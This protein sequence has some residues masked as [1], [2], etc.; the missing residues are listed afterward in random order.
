MSEAKK[1]GKRN[2]FFNINIASV[3]IQDRKSEYVDRTGISTTAGSVPISQQDSVELTSVIRFALL[4]NY[5]ATHTLRRTMCVIVYTQ[6]HPRGGGQLSAATWSG[7]R[8][9]PLQ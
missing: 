9:A 2:A 7:G 3:I 1:S 8:R 5:S 4:K 6:N